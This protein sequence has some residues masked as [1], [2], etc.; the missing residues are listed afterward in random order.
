MG[1]RGRDRSDVPTSPGGLANVSWQQH[2]EERGMEGFGSELPEEHTLPTPG[3]WA[4]GLLNY[5]R[6]N[7]CS[8]QPLSVWSF[9]IANTGS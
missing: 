2:R 1:D 7:F 6:I 3:L 9:V 5:E 4:S 8:F